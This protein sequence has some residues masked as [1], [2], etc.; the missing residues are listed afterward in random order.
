MTAGDPLPRRGALGLRFEARDGAVRVL[1][2]N[3]GA[4]AHAAGIVTE[5]LL[6]GADEVTFSDEPTFRRWAGSLRADEPVALRVARGPSVET[7]SLRPTP[8]PIERAPGLLRAYTH[9]VL[10]DGTRLRVIVTRPEDAP[11]RARVLALPGY[12]R[13]G[14]D[15]PA[16]P[17]YPLRRWIEDVARAGYAVI[18]IERR[19]LGDSEG[20]GDEQTLEE[21]FTDL[22]DAARAT[23]W[24]PL[25]GLPWVLHGFSLGGLLAPRMAPLLGARAVSVWGSG[26]DTW[27]EYLDALTRRRG[28]LLGR[29]ELAVERSVRA[30]QALSAAVLVLG[31]TVARAIE[32]TPS[33]REHASELGLDPARDR[34][35]GRPAR[36]WRQVYSCPT[37]EPLAALDAPL[38]SLWGTC[39]WLTDRGEHERIARACARGTFAAVPGVDHGYASRASPAES[40]RARDPGTYA[41]QSAHTFISW[42]GSVSL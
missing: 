25:E 19:G 41:P 34:I 42:L 27:T 30:Q 8:R 28:A 36:F 16:A 1:S 11:C 10:P 32:R 9:A 12:R 38:L 31:E 15:W 29:S 5:D 37:A 26:I 3:E 13:D 6:L 33:L 21:E 4:S 23:P 7:I 17:D 39:D 24:G 35:D 2:V 20:E 40:L 14:W 22:L 18:R